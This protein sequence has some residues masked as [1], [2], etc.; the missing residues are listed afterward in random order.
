M[1]LRASALC[2]NQLKQCHLVTW[3]VKKEKSLGHHSRNRPI[4]LHSLGTESLDGDITHMEVALPEPH[5]ATG[6]T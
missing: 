2:G 6:G 4:S 3:G 1:R 5:T